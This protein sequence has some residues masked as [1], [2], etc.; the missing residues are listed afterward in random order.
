MIKVNVEII[1]FGFVRQYKYRTYL[2]FYADCQIGLS[3]IGIVVSLY[4]NRGYVTR[5]IASISSCNYVFIFICAY[6]GTYILCL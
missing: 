3:N 1:P 4:S 5:K 6:I 2:Q